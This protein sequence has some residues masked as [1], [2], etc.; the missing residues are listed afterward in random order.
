MPKKGKITDETRLA[1]LATARKKSLETRRKNKKIKELKKLEEQEKLKKY[2]EMIVKEKK[3]EFKEEIVN[4]GVEVDLNDP[5]EARAASNES[6]QD[7]NI[8]NHPSHSRFGELKMETPIDVEE[9]VMM[10]KEPQ[11]E[12]EDEPQKAPEPEPDTES[13][14]DLFQSEEEY[15]SE[16]SVESEE[17]ELPPPPKRK[18]RKKSKRHI[19]RVRYYSSSSD[20]DSDG[21]IIIRRRKPKKNILYYE[22][23]EEYLRIKNNETF[24]EP[25]THKPEQET[26]EEKEKDF[27]REKLEL[28]KQSL[29][30][31]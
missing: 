2:E 31:I 16:K 29:F 17:E 30:S 27:F 24:V 7:P 28:A 15:Y 10:L 5:I 1:Q 3:V 9:P 23:L 25:P 19:K 13:E 6:E 18:K 4:S 20:S 22:D 26:P 8:V 21:Q 12:P 11:P 14:P